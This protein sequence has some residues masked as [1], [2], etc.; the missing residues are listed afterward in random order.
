MYKKDIIAVDLEILQTKCDCF[1]DCSS[2]EN[3][4]EVLSAAT[5]PGT[6]DEDYKMKVAKILSFAALHASS[7]T[8]NKLGEDPRMV[9]C[10]KLK[11]YLEVQY[12]CLAIFREAYA[13]TDDHDL[14]YKISAKYVEIAT[15]MKNA[16]WTYYSPACSEYI[17]GVPVLSPAEKD[18]LLKAIDEWGKK[19]EIHRL[20]REW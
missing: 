18:L 14:N 1:V 13:L 6:A 19:R 7:A 4:D 20:G 10:E 16:K 2:Y 11:D 9:S 8:Q 15:N 17:E 12:R 3:F 5:I